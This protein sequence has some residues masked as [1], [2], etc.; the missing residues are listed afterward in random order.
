MHVGTLIPHF[1]KG[2]FDKLLLPVPDRKLQEIIGDMY[3]ELSSKIELNRRTNETLEAMARAIFKAWF[4]DFDPVIAK[5]EGH[6]PDGMDAET[7]KLFPNSLV[8]SEIGQVPKGWKV[9]TVGDVSDINAW[10]LGKNDDLNP[11]E[12]VE[13]SEV[14]RGDIG[15]IQVFERGEEPSR[16][17]R[18]LRHGD[19]VLST[20]RPDRRSYFLCL[21]PSPSL[22]ASTGFAV[23]SPTR[24]PWSFLHAGLTQ[25]DV[26]EHLGQ[27]A[28]G[29][30]YPAVRPEVI[31]QWRLPLPDNSAVL[32]AF[33]SVCSRLFEK[34][35]EDRRQ[36]MVLSQLRDSLLPRLLS[37]EL[38]AHKARGE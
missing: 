25:S 11:I 33:H 4:V 27:H 9:T 5:S 36:T 24:V 17:R 19:T 18:R 23:L 6:Q 16:A 35:E 2:D 1:K 34:A 15:N 30:A 31:G 37:G 12:Y 20:V 7:A 21:H 38:S 14:S 29:G 13:I 22:I 32:D 3:F 10:T 28:D 8:D 26:F